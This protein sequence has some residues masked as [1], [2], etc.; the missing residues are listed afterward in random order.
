MAS[1]RPTIA[2][3]MPFAKGFHRETVEVQKNI[4]RI[5]PPV[6]AA[7][8][9]LIR[10]TLKTVMI[11]TGTYQ[12]FDYVEGELG[13]LGLRP[14]DINLVINTHEHFDHIGGNAHLRHTALIA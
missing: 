3:E 5:T 11:D 13:K 9:Y 10:D 2:D 4:W 12:S 1:R 14:Q 7:N 6:P 8:I